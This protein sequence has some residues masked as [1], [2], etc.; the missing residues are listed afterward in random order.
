MHHQLARWIPRRQR[1]LALDGKAAKR[2]DEEEQAEAEQ[3][4]TGE[5]QPDSAAVVL[6]EN[7]ILFRRASQIGTRT[8]TVNG[9]ITME[10]K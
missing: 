1:A 2:P 4:Q 8:V 3:R 5:L 7:E 10:S 9:R 6:M